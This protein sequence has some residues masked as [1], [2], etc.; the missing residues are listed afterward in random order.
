[1]I[2]LAAR[3]GMGKTA[4]GLNVLMHA[5]L[6]HGLNI[7]FFSLEMTKEMLM[8][9]MLSAQSK[10]NFSKIRTGFLS[11]S[12]FKKVVDAAATLQGASIYI[13]DTPAINALELRARTRRL[14]SDKGIDL[15]VVDYLQLMRGA[16]GS[17]SRERE[18]AD[19]S[20]SLKALAKELKIPIIA[21][22]QLSRQTE[23]RTDKKPQLSDLRE[24]GALEQDADMVLFLHRAD[25]YKRNVE[26]RDGLA[27]V[28][29]GK[30]RNGPTGTVSLAFLDSQGVPSFENLADDHLDNFDSQ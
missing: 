16:K 8:M 3:P 20:S 26:E 9:R 6:I 30:Q 13:D 27:E 10:I 22:S 21:I 23:S 19:I 29:I 15:L 28:I 12:E 5:G 14:K 7:A 4:F 2:I 17:E 1:L 18:I 11:D 24:S 25:A